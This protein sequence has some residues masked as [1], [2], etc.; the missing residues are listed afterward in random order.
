MKNRIIILLLSFLLFQTLSA[1]NLNIKSKNITLDKKT[2]LT[3]FK[4]SVEAV[5]ENENI[6]KQIMLSIIKI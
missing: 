2:R 1:E 6:F 5:D 4:D 3:I